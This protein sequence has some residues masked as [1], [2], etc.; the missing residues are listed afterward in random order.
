MVMSLFADE[1]AE[2]TVKKYINQG[3]WLECSLSDY[4]TYLEYY[5]E[6]GY[7]SVHRVMDRFTGNYKVLKRSSKKDFVKGN[8][9][10]F[11]T[12]K[13]L[14]SVKIGSL[15]LDENL[16][17][18]QEAEFMVQIHQKLGG[19][20]LFDYYDDD[21][22]YILIMEDG[23]RSLESIACS[24][25][26]KII[27]L[28]RYKNY[29][30][31]FFYHTYLKQISQYLIKIYHQ[32]KDIHDLGI[33]HNDLKPEN[34]LVCGEKITIIDYGVAKKVEESY[35]SYHGTL[36]YVPFEFVKNGSYKPWD[37]TIWCFGIM[38]HFLTLMKY[39]F[40]KEEEVLDYNLDY[41]KINKLPQSFSNL[42]FD[43]LQKNPLNRPQNLL[44]RLENLES[45]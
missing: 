34:I 18:S 2:K 32:I 29:Q 5:D 10:A 1:F 26:K 21:D 16:Y 4:Y 20:E 25:R 36:E 41:L 17:A 40:I 14:E 8:L 27:D 30:T 38:L 43:C 39:P 23:G 19:L 13:Y 44:E 22:H 31:N 33:H 7:G 45:Y 28:I 24:H 37:H 35:T 6:G 15:Q 11:H 9:K 3:I 12:Q 42:I